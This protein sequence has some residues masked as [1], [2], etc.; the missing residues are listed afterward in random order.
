MNTGE[1]PRQ[2][3]EGHRREDVLHVKG[4]MM[5]DSLLTTCMS[6]SALHC[7]VKLHLSGLHEEKCTI[8]KKKK[9]LG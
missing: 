1:R 3:Q 2:T 6:W 7:V 5:K 9:E 4:H 8:K